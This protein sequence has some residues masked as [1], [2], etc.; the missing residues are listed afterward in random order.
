MRRTGCR[1][2][3]CVV[4]GLFV[5]GTVSPSIGGE[6]EKAEEQAWNDFLKQISIGPGALDVGGSFRMRYEFY[7]NFTIKKYNTDDRGYLLLERFRLNLDYRLSKDL[8]G[9]VQLQDAHYWLSDLHTRDFSQACPYENP[10]DLK[11]AYLEWRHIGDTP[12]GFKA[13]RQTIAYRKSRVWGPGNWGNVGRYVWDAAKLNVDTELLELDGIYGQRVHYDFNQ[14]DEDHW[15]FDV[16]ALY[17]KLKK[18]PAKVDLFYTYKRDHHDSTVGEDGTDDLDSHSAGVWVDGVVRDRIDYGGVFAYQFGDWGKDRIRAYGFNARSGYTFAAPW[19]PRIGAQ[20]S[21]AT[22]DDAGA[23]GKHETFDGLLGS[24][25]T[26]YGRMNL[27]AWKN[28]EDYEANFSVKPS[29]R[30]KIY[31]DYHFLKLAEREDAWYYCTGK[32]QR[33][34]ATGASGSTLGQEIDVRVKYDVNKY[35]KL[36]FGY[37]HFFPGRYVRR[38][39]GGHHDADWFYLQTTFLF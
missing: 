12:L 38:T 10:L 28:L 25:A 31:V 2:V 30:I 17:A 34:D 21:C 36:M 20:I 15:D 37:S 23:D 26:F 13:G 7:D 1:A 39:A 18:L 11:Q 16:C 33:R 8:H 6:V 4:I 3:R 35:V 27:V 22:G 14:F 9:F 19:K 29:K 5:L 32:A 24:V